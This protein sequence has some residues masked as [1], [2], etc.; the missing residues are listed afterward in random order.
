[1][2]VDEFDN[3]NPESEEFEY[4]C[5]IHSHRTFTI[6]GLKNRRERERTFK[7]KTNMLTLRIR[8]GWLAMNVPQIFEDGWGSWL[9]NLSEYE[10]SNLR[11]NRS[12]LE[13]YKHVIVDRLFK[14]R[15]N[16]FTS[17]LLIHSRL[18]TLLR[19]LEGKL[20][21]DYIPELPEGWYS[22]IESSSYCVRELEQ[23]TCR[24]VRSHCATVQE[25][26]QLAH[27]AVTHTIMIEKR[28]M[29]L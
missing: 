12:G 4:L 23:K 25:F 6:F 29:M 16:E 13:H 19:R 10:I 14:K 2:L 22:I 18:T 9:D 7:V 17:L 26:L 20:P 21:K 28:D 3:H 8:Y 24:V 11:M 5:E 15:S 27:P 1:M